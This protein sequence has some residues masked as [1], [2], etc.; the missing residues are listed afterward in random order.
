MTLGEHTWLGADSVVLPGVRLGNHVYVAAGS[1]VDRSFDEN[2]VLLA[3]VP[4]RVVK[5]LPP[6]RGA[7]YLSEPARP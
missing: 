6:Y 4:A 5:K 7:D 3:G 2:D 1:V